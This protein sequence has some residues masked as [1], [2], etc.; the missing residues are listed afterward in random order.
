MSGAKRRGSAGMD[1]RPSPHRENWAAWVSSPVVW[2]GWIAG[3]APTGRTGP[4]GFHHRLFGRD[5]SPAEPPPGELGRVG[6]ITGC[7]AGM[8]RRP[9]PHRENWAAW[10]SSPVVWPGWIAARTPRGFHHRLFGGMERPNAAWVSP[11]AVKSRPLS[12]IAPALRAGHRNSDA[13]QRRTSA[14]SDWLLS[15]CERGKSPPFT[16]P[17]ITPAARS[18]RRRLNADLWKALWGWMA[19][20]GRG[21][22]HNL[23]LTGA[24]GQGDA[25]PGG[26]RGG[27]RRYSRPHRE[28]W[29]TPRPAGPRNP[30][31]CRQSDQT[32]RIPAPPALP[33]VMPDSAQDRIESRLSGRSGPT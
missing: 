4:R 27:G 32:T 29:P 16:F 25:G 10:V 7:L 9:S 28:S 33:V 1:R 3:R 5:G 26:R 17:P 11:Q 13:R 31:R 21:Q 23:G 30:H 14:S 18:A 12:G 8:D 15:I 24:A 2:P 20:R 19:A 22:A 6:F